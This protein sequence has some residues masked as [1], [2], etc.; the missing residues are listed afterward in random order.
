MPLVDLYNERFLRIQHDTDAGWLH[1]DWTGYQ[2]IDSV[3]E[4]CEEILRRMVEHRVFL[5]LNDNTHVLGIWS[6]ASRWVATDW[7]PRMRAVG[8]QR[9][10][11]VYSPSRLSQVST[12]E[13]L[14][15]VDAA[16]VGVGVF[17]D[18]ADAWRWLREP[19]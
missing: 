8:L 17:H 5:I 16:A 12:D 11:W 9:F 1:A 13:A 14:A 18:I 3:K 7:F 19:S 6:G 2:T 15:G 10:A 4:G